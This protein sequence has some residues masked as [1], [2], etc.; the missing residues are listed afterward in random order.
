[1]SGSF[2]Q[3]LGCTE[4]EFLLDQAIDPTLLLLQINN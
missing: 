4:F 2:N 1:M 3:A